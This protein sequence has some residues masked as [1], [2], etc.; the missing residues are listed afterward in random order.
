VG[1]HTVKVEVVA[2][3]MNLIKELFCKPK[4]LP[5]PDPVQSCTEEPLVLP[6]KPLKSQTAVA[7]A[8][9]ELEGRVLAQAGKFGGKAA[10]VL[11]NVRLQVFNTPELPELRLSCMHKLQV[12]LAFCPLLTDPK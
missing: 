11:L 7:L 1:T 10:G 5:R 4:Q 3:A 12:P 9:D 6:H 2:E 8:H